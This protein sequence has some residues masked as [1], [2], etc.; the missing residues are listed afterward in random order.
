MINGASQSLRFDLS[1]AGVQVKCLT[2]GDTDLALDLEL[3]G[4]RYAVRGDRIRRQTTMLGTL[5]TVQLQSEPDRPWV[6]FG[7]MLPDV[8]LNE[9]T[10]HAR[11][12]LRTFA[13][14]S[15]GAVG[16]RPDDPGPIIPETQTYQ[17]FELAGTVSL[18]GVAVI[19]C[20]QWSAVRT[21]GADRRDELTVEGV[22]AFPRGGY[23][24]QL[25][26][27]TEQGDNLEDFRLQL[28]SASRQ[29]RQPTRRPPSLPTTRR[30]MATS[31]Q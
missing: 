17:L 25:R 5:I 8:A 1:G 22:C 20:R 30:G 24:V 16:R 2:G 9:D 7:L 4:A 11:E 12:R 28:T 3:D 14:R 29:G 18:V 23:T 10:G 27:A 13:V 15:T 21:I 6:G 31:R 26:P 19:G